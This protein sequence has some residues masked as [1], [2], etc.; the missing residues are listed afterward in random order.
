[1]F[2]SVPT[3]VWLVLGV[4]FLAL[5]AGTL[6]RLI[7]LARSA[8]RAGRPRERLRSLGTWW[9]LF[10]LLVTIVVLGRPAA[11][12]L[13][14]MAS[15]Q[16]LR[17]Y[18]HLTQRRIVATRLWWWAYLAVPIHY[19]LVYDGATWLFFTFIP[20]W[21][22]VV[23]LTSLVATGKTSDFLEQSGITFLGLMQIVFLLSHAALVMSL[24]ANAHFPSGTIGLFVYLIVLTESNDIAQAIWGRRFGRRKIVPLV[25]PNKTWEGMLLGTA[26]TTVLAVVLAGPLTPFVDFPTSMEPP[27]LTIPYFPAAMVGLLIAIGGF[28][29]DITISAMKREVGAK[30]SGDL[31]PGQGGILD[32]IDSLTFTAPLFF[33]FIYFLYA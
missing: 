19:A 5:A 2:A 27:G 4:I 22:F 33:Y 13:F 21:V 25:S 10:L 11:V 28:F 1:M 8:N 14:A 30:D 23:L 7:T 20:V 9:V 26:T 12:V 16:G 32:R 18:R 29:G 15:L 17:E 24:P 6:I 3:D 31:L